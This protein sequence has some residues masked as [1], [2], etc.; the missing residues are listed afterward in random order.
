MALRKPTSRAK[1]TSTEVAMQ[2]PVMAPR[3]S[4][5]FSLP[6][7]PMPTTWTPLLMVLLMVASFLLGM[8]ITKVQYLEGQQAGGTTAGTQQAAG[9]AQPS[10]APG[11]PVNV[12]VGN[13]P[14]LGNKDA[15][16]KVVEFADFQCPFCEQ[17]FSQVMPQLKKDYIDTGKIA[18]YWR[19]YPF[20]G[21]ESNYAASAARCANDQGKFWDFHDYLYTHQGQENSGAFSKDNLKQFAATMGLNTDQFNSCLDADKFSK[22]YQTD[23]SDGQKA[24]VN[25]TPTVFVN[26]IAIVGA[27]PYEAFKSAIDTALKK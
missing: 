20:L 16:V 6:K 5:T 23:L 14:A 12:S 25:G 27:Q 10:V 21:Q 19:D 3:S 7:L 22:D 8:L 1:K 17:W 24:G 26:G 18:F 9:G 4:K 13:L 11:T 15:K 2:E